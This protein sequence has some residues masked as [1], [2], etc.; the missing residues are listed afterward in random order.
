M[1]PASYSF[2]LKKSVSAWIFR[3]GKESEM[4]PESLRDFS[5]LMTTSKKKNG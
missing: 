2:E 5:L 4:V 1:V 3:I